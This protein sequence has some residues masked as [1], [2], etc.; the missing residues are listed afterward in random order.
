MEN[1]DRSQVFGDPAAPYENSL[2]T[3]GVNYTDDTGGSHPSL[4]NYLALYAGSTLGRDGNDACIRSGAANLGAAAVAAGLSFKVFAEDLGTQDPTTD[5][6]AY[7]CRHN[8]AAQFTDPASTSASTDFTEFPTDFARLP[9]ISYVIPNLCADTHH[10]PVATGDAWLRSHIDTYAQWAKANGS[11]LILTWDENAGSDLTTP[12]GLV[13]VGGGITPSVQTAH[14]T[15]ESVLRTV[16]DW[17]GL[18]PFGN[19]SG[20]TGLPGLSR[21]GLGVRIGLGIPSSLRPMALQRRS[22]HD[23]HDAG[24]LRERRDLAQHHEAGERGRGREQ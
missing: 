17:H 16:E 12:I 13:V 24:G 9:T 18:A 8:P 5:H 15:H 2:G 1:R 4:P 14:V 22:A 7:A 23:E 19:T 3:Q 11:A 21:I 6:G 10:C 20:V